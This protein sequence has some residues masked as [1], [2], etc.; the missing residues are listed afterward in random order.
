MSFAKW[1]PFFPRG[2]ELNSRGNGE[3]PITIWIQEILASMVKLQLHIDGLIWV[4]IW[5]PFTDTD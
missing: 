3:V 2:D 4:D 1:R 5:G